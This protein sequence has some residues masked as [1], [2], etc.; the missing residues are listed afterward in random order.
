MNDPQLEDILT[1]IR[2]SASFKRMLALHPEIKQHHDL[3][4]FKILL[5]V[6][7]FD[8]VLGTVSWRNNPLICGSLVQRVLEHPAGIASA[9]LEVRQLWK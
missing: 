3:G 6:H 7:A 5:I 4:S 1:R 2:E 8:D 9:V